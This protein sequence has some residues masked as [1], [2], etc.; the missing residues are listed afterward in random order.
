MAKKKEN[1][2]DRR[3]KANEEKSKKLGLDFKPAEKVTKKKGGS[4]ISGAAGKKLGKIK[5]FFAERISAS[6]Q[7]E[8][9]IAKIR[10]DEF[11]V[12]IENISPMHL[13]SG[14]ADVN[15]DADVV[16]DENGL[17]Y[18]PGKRLKGLLYESGMEVLE[19]LSACG[20]DCYSKDAW[21]KLFNHGVEGECR[22]IIPNVNLEGYENIS[23]E[24]GALIK[25]FP[26][27]FQPVDVLG[28]YTTIRYQTRIDS[29]TGVAADTSLHNM[30]VVDVHQKFAGK[31]KITGGRLEH[32]E[33]LALA[34]Q[35]LQQSG[36]KRNRGFGEIKCTMMQD[37]KNIQ[38]ILVQQ[39]WKRGNM[40]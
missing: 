15:V 10:A 11:D 6:L 34:F 21:D 17:P 19:M 36:L 22:L 5:D 16:H 38:N 40:I 24:W 13:G 35:N 30:R 29:A 8:T 32:L 33:L 4:S 31:I 26:S 14:Q 28:A 23:R 3:R 1:A 12:M 2:A 39:A 20:S 7:E 25:A 27:M 37:G 9:N 18:F